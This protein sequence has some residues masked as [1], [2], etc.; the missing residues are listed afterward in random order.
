MSFPFPPS[1]FSGRG[2]TFHP[3]VHNHSALMLTPGL[4][5]TS[6]VLEKCLPVPEVQ[7]QTKF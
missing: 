7:L 5:E 6:R 1:D 4:K 2:T 3:R